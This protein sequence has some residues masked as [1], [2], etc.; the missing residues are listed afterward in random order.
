MGFINEIQDDIDKIKTYEDI[1]YFENEEM[2]LLVSDNRF[3]FRNI[4]SNEK[5]YIEYNLKDNFDSSEYSDEEMESIKMCIET[6]E[7]YD[8]Y[9]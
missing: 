8:F 9:V 7:E 5:F 3:N 6:A 1:G 4:I 2:V